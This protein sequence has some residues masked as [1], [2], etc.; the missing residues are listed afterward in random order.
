MGRPPI[1]PKKKKDGYYLD[2]RNKGAKSGIIIIRDTEKEMMQA[3]RQYENTKDVII[4]GEH[5][6]GKRVE[7]KK[8]KLHQKE[9]A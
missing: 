6:N 9:K 7:E 3:V 1:L 4:L 2:I 8:K 5:R